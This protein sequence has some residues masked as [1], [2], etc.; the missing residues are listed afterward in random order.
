MAIVQTSLSAPLRELMLK[1][2]GDSVGRQ[3]LPV[4]HLPTWLS[5]WLQL[6]HVS[7]LLDQ[8]LS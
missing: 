7:W 8:H 1:L 6:L 5:Y 4:G 2:V 3:M